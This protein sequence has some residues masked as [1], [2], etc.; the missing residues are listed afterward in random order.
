MTQTPTSWTILHTSGE[1]Q[2]A[3]SK[4]GSPLRRKGLTYL[5][6]PFASKNVCLR[7][8]SMH[9]SAFNPDTSQNSDGGRH[10]KTQMH[11]VETVRPMT[12][13]MRK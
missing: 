11:A 4:I 3:L 13:N 7:P 2:S 5:I 6:M 1:C 10:S 8:G 9:L 12:V